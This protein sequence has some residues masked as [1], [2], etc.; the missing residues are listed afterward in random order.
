MDRNLKAFLDTIAWSE[1]GAEILAQSDNGYNVLAGSLPGMVI[2][3]SS[4]HR[5]PGVLVDMDGKPGGIE[6]TAAGRYQLLARWWKPYCETLGLKDFGKEAQDKIALQQIKERR[7]IDC[8]F[9]GQIAD[10]IDRCRNIWASFP[11]AGYGQHENKLEKLLSVF[12][13]AGGVVADFYHDE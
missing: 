13:E 3:F 6:S 2:T 9:N 10:A 11:G 4:Y 8:I 1:L 7:A 5:H 12:A